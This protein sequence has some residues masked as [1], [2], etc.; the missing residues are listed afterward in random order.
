M[1]ISLPC[2]NG[3]DC[4]LQDFC[5]PDYGDG[6]G[7]FSVIYVMNQSFGLKLPA[8]PCSTLEGIL[9]HRILDIM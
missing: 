2:S 4:R 7:L 8:L 5:L 9:F 6:E 1:P 3:T